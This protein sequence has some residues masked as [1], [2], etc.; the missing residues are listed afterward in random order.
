VQGDAGFAID[1]AGD[2]QA[3]PRMGMAVRLDTEGRLLALAAQGAMTEAMRG[4]V[5]TSEHKGR[6]VHS[7]VKDM[8]GSLGVHFAL[9]GDL[10]VLATDR[11]MVRAAIDA[12]GSA[13]AGRR[14][15]ATAAMKPGWCAFAHFDCDRLMAAMDRLM[16]S[17]PSMGQFKQILDMYRELAVLPAHM[18]MAT[19]VPDDMAYVEMRA[20]AWM[21]PAAAAHPKS[22]VEPHWRASLPDSTFC[23]WAGAQGFS[24]MW[25]GMKLGMGS[26]GMEMAQI[27]Q[28]FQKAIGLE[29]EKQVIPALGDEMLF[30]L[31]YVPGR[32]RP[33]AAG[34]PAKIAIPGITLGLGVRDEAVVRKVLDK[35]LELARDAI[36]ESEPDRKGDLVS[37]ETHGGVVLFVA[38]LTEEEQAMVPIRPAL[39]L[40]DGWL[41]V[42]T[43]ADVARSMIDARRGK[44][45]GF[46]ASPVFKRASGL[47][48]ARNAGEYLVDWGKAMDEVREM[49]PMFGQFVPGGPEVPFPDFPDDGDE[50]EWKRRI[51]KYQAE[52]EKAQSAG[53]ER[54]VKWI[55]ALRCIDHFA[56]SSHCEGDVMDGVFAVRFSE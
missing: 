49:A 1:W 11:D 54:I 3:M 52:S 8:P 48:G 46:T 32:D 35:A 43:E 56:S 27:E 16:E 30:A 50:E 18:G 55:D 23:Y 13:A 19:Y 45:P 10:L 28:E 38:N 6:A 44:A 7:F 29:L 4:V 26:A 53:G 5:E 21:T 47:L 12:S 40:G 15:Q 24:D 14:G 36:R 20:R 41:F 42:S 25:R 9:V 34:G 2:T 33:N 37:T 17:E 39:A 31:S 22:D 51:E